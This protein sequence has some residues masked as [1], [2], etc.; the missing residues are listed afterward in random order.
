MLTKDQKIHEVKFHVEICFI[1]SGKSP[2][3]INLCQSN[4]LRRSDTL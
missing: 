2:S 4:E 3:I 1:L